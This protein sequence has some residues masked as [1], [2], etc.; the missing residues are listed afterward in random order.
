MLKRHGIAHVMDPVCIALQLVMLSKISNE[1]EGHRG[2]VDEIQIGIR[3]D[4]K[5]EVA[6]QKHNGCNIE[7]AQRSMNE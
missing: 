3:T 4:T 2:R 5:K 1:N 7:H 6:N